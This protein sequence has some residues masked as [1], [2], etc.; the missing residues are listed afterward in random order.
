M[1]PA[2]I[3]RIHNTELILSDVLNSPSVNVI[4]G[5][6]PDIVSGYKPEPALHR[7]V[8]RLLPPGV[9]VYSDKS[10]PLVIISC[11]ALAG[12]V[13]KSTTS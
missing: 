10:K 4:L 5:V 2:A 7:T 9:Q 8:T 11:V 13:S 1:I 12:S 3:P 6:D